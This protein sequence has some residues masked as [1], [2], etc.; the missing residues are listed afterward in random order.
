MPA[1]LVFQGQVLTDFQFAQVWMPRWSHA[2]QGEAGLSPC[3][4]GEV[5]TELFT[6]AEAG[7]TAWPRTFKRGEA[8][9]VSEE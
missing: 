5:R 9:G 2:R 4:A 8:S 1:T 7:L 6:T 3:E